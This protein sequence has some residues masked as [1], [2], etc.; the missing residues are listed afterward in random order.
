MT[1][2]IT[3]TRADVNVLH[4]SLDE[5]RA[6]ADQLLALS[7]ALRT[8]GM[9]PSARSLERIEGLIACHTIRVA[10]VIVQSD[11]AQPIDNAIQSNR[12]A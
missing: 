5:I 6:A 4:D 12:E 9:K 11:D 7:D 10:E 8:L 3:L 1:D 2:T